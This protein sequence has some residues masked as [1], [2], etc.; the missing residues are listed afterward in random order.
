MSNSHDPLPPYASRLDALHRAFLDDFRTIVG[1]L[2]LTGSERIIDTGCGDGFF[3]GLLAERLATG[4]VLGVDTSPA[5]LAAAGK[6]LQHAI[7][8]QR[9]RLLEADVNRLPLEDASLDAVWSAHS[10]QSY[11]AIPHVLGEFRRVLRPGGRLV[12]VT[13]GI[14]HLRELRALL[15]G[16]FP[17]RTFSDE[18]APELLGRHFVR[19]EERDAGGW[20][21]FPDRAA[22][23]SYV[24]A[25]R[26]L[27]ERELPSGFD[28]PLRV[29]RAP[30]IYIAT[31]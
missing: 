13:N 12:A 23:Q 20:I 11:D 22:V 19:V 8:E 31:R 17:T 28:G 9:C 14:D 4:E 25:T 1:K 30:V 3:T 6:R 16:D 2:P 26:T 10:M 27:W 7:G 15:G 18:T 21:N 5:Y 29:R 24:D